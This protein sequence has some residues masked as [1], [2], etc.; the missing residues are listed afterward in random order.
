[1]QW[2]E[3]IES[4]SA[5]NTGSDCVLA[6][7]KNEL[8]W[9]ITP[10]MLTGLMPSTVAGSAG[11][12]VRKRERIDRTN[13]GREKAEMGYDT[14]PSSPDTRAAGGQCA[15]LLATAHHGCS[16]KCRMASQTLSDAMSHH[17]RQ[18]RE[19]N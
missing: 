14:N 6:T 10:P 5:M 7:Q 1:M 4:E 18:K 15:R 11:Q 13:C 8:G 12:P 3:F 17:R 2:H 16:H 9:A 19:R